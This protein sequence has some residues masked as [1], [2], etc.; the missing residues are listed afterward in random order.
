MDE[1]IQLAHE[2][3]NINILIDDKI[4]YDHKLIRGIDEGKTREFYPLAVT[5]SSYLANMKESSKGGARQ[6]A[7]KF[8]Y[9]IENILSDIKLKR[10]DLSEMTIVIYPELLNPYTGERLED[11]ELQQQTRQ[12]LISNRKE[13]I[14]IVYEE[15]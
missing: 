4:E 15:V 1:V 7:R 14:E 9:Y 2:Q 6:V 8:S 10:K 12:A 3:E 5:L 13:D 11:E